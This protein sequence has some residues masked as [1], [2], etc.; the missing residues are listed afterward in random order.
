[1]KISALFK[2]CLFVFLCVNCLTIGRF[3]IFT[4]E[5]HAQTLVPGLNLNSINN[6]TANKKPVS[7]AITGKY[8]EYQSI[9]RSPKTEDPLV[10][11]TEDKK[12]SEALDLIKKTRY[13]EAI[14]QLEK[15]LETK[16]ENIDA[17]YAISYAYKKYNNLYE[18]KSAL[19]DIIKLER[20]K[21][22]KLN[23]IQKKYLIDLCALE[24]QDSNHND[25]EDTCKV[26][27]KTLPEEIL[28]LIYLSVSYRE[29]EK[30]KEALELLEK[31]LKIKKSEFA[32]T[33]RAE[34]YQL[35]KKSVNAI[36]AYDESI[37]IDAESA[38][39][40]LGKAQIQYDLEKYDEA[41]GSFIM[42]CKLDKTYSFHFRKA[43]AELEKTKNPISEKY[44]A[45]IKQC[46]R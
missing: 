2:I 12:V 10:L 35:Q 15:I 13:R 46:L 29:Q 31:S 40:Y 19:Q 22:K 4:N 28:P 37:A 32:L 14:G 27:I 24:V 43:Q 38:R 9:C 17:L 34:I 39:A 23:L 5:L 16:S 41:L 6:S 44:Y 25:A 21:K 11:E 8:Y 26:V 18:A 33:C 20:L 3:G 7:G 36:K 45:S 1:M 30:Y 42:A